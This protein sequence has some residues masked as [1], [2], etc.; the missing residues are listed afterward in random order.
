MVEP[1]DAAQLPFR[2]GLFLWAD[3]PTLKQKS[4]PEGLPLPPGMTSAT[5][6]LIS[7]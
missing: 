3:A 4:R 2:G 6:L 5:D 7:E 1:Q